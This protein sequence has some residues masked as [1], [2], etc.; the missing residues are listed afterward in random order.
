MSLFK[1]I[2]EID[3]KFIPQRFNLIMGWIS[4]DKTSDYKWIKLSNQID[5]CSYNTI[6]DARN[7]FKHS[8][9]KVHKV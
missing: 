6:E 3:G 4:R 8:F 1:R 5:Y 2:I 7:S 9:Y